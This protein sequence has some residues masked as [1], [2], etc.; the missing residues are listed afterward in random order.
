MYVLKKYLNR[1]LILFLF[2]TFFV[3]STTPVMA[4]GYDKALKGAKDYKAVYEFSQGDPKTANLIFWAVK[5][6]Y[7]VDEV[8]SIS[9]DRDVVVVFHGPVVKLLSTNQAPFNAVEWAEVEK[10]HDTIR[11]MKKDGVKFE[12]C[13]YAVKVL[14]V[15][16]STIIPEIDKVGNGFV[17]VIGYQMQDYAVVRVP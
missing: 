4:A 1:S 5:N 7:E 6:S 15:D 12:V 3:L 10:F 2:T 16:E 17:S 13:L 14:G 9:G 11:T 8:K